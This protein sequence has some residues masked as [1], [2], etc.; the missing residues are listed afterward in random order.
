MSHTYVDKMMEKMKT[1]DLISP[2][3]QLVG[4]RV[5]DF[6]R[7]YTVYELE[8]RP[9][10]ANPMGMVQGGI[11]SILADAAM[12]MAATTTMTNDQM[13]VE[14]ITTVDLYSRFMRPV[15]AKKVEKLRAEARVIR[16]GKFIVWLECD[17]TAD[18]E[19]VAKFSATGSRVSFDQ[20]DTAMKQKEQ[21]KEPANA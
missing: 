9:E 4:M 20:K 2:V 1:G 21:E 8:V 15:N 14:A 7:G 3:E 17:L 11:A 19:T 10:H 13:R 12:A 18:G 16:T 5:C 6:G